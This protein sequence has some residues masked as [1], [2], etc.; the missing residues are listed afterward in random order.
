MGWWD[1]RVQVGKLW[2]ANKFS[3]ATQIAE[4]KSPEAR[5]LQ[6]IIE[7]GGIRGRDLQKVK[8]A[9]E[10]FGTFVN[11][12]IKSLVDELTKALPHGLPLQID[13]E[14]ESAAQIVANQLLNLLPKQLMGQLAEP[15]KSSKPY[16]ETAKQ[17]NEYWGSLTL[18]PE[19]VSGVT[20]ELTEALTK[21]A[22]A[23]G[24]SAN[25][26]DAFRGRLAAIIELLPYV[27][28]EEDT[29]KKLQVAAA[30]LEKLPPIPENDQAVAT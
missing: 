12:R 16:V 19:I 10:T 18:V 23:Y 25:Q 7:A 5:D 11:E 22:V 30:L 20:D 24:V 21:C 28:K 9:A 8:N 14:T 15:S 17:I 27:A 29:S 1:P 26:L 6:A 4:E 2:L 13:K 3:K